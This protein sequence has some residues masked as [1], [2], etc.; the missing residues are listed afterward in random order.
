MRV[1]L[2]FALSISS[3]FAQGSFSTLRGLVTDSTGAVI[4]AA[5]IT[6]KEPATGVLVREIPAD[7]QGAFEIP[8]LRAGTY[9]LTCSAPGF[10]LFTANQIALAS[11]QL[12]RL[13][14]QLSVADSTQT[15]NVT[16][17][18]ALINTETG[19]I[20]GSYDAKK[21]ADVPLVDAYPSPSAMLTVIPGFQGGSGGLGGVR[22][23]GQGLG[24]I[25][26]AI[27][28]INNDTAGQVVNS[29]QYEEVNA[30]VVNAPAESS[31]IASV[32][33]ITKRGAN[34]FHGI[35]YYKFFSSAFNARSFFAPRRTP[36][37]QH[38]WDLELGGAIIKNKTFF[39]AS[40]FS[41]R[42]PLGSFSTA[43]VPTAAFRNGTFANAI[44]DPQTNQP[45]PGNQIPASRVSPVS[46]KIQD[47]YLPLPTS[48]AAA[49]N[50]AFEVPFPADLFRGDWLFWRLDHNFSSKN[51]ADVRWTQRKT[52]YVLSSGL[53]GQFWTRKRDHQ[54]WVASD[55]H[56]FSPS[57]INTL[58]FGLS[59]DFI[60]DGDTVSGRTPLD[61]S[62]VLTEI[63]LLGSNPSGFKGQ[64]FPTI[65][66]T[67]LTG[68][69][70]QPGGVVNDNSAY[71]INQSI[72]KTAG[73]HVWKSGATV[74]WQ[75][76]FA[77]EIPNYGSVSFDGTLSGAPYADFLLG[78]PR[79]SSRT[80]PIANRRQNATEIG[81]FS[82]DSFKV[83]NRL[84][85]EYGLRWDYYTSPVYAD[86]LMYNFDRA[87]GGIIVPQAALAKVSPLYPKNIAISAG[88]PQPT[89]S[90]SNLRPRFSAAYRITPKF[91]IRGG[92]G[93]FTER[94]ALFQ[95]VSG[96]GPFQIAETYQNQ[97]GQTQGL[98]SF[99]NPYP[100]S[101]ATATVASQ[102]VVSFPKQTTNGILHQYNLSLER[103]IFG[104]GLRGSYVGSLGR[105][106]NYS[107]NA[108][109][110][111]PSLIAF[112]VN[113]RPF[114]NLV[115]V[116]DFRADG[117]SYYQSAQ[118]EAKRR[119]GDFQ[120]DFN[121]SYQ[122]NKS[123]YFNLENPYS[124]L[125]KWANEANTR[126][127]YAVGSVVWAAPVGRG[128]R[129]LSNAPKAVDMAIG[130]WQFYWLS[131]VASGLFF[132]PSYS[133]A[134][135]SNTGVNGG[136][137]DLI[138]NP[139]G[140]NQTKNQWFDPKAY[141]VPAAGRFGNALPNSLVSQPL[142]VHHLSLIKKFPIKERLSFTF[143]AAISN[144][145]NHATFN[146]PLNNISVAGT[147]AFS[148][149]VGVFSSN[150]RGAFR[151][152]T[153]KGRFDF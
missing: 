10:S 65:S 16:A 85:L 93:M 28:G 104:F 98:I 143:T 1:L 17:G 86:G 25:I 13:D 8:G 103:E 83:T 29:E 102:S 26:V 146:N 137:P 60:I 49:N 150:E 100:A 61:G 64:G 53:P 95:R 14:V 131:Y 42:I 23:N 127:H 120:V 67:G 71:T 91:V 47:K 117:S 112:N 133:G 132:S 74:Q 40:W 2:L 138:G 134:S 123:N 147:G 70:L 4:P 27:D 45:F 77:G 110:P 99:P 48:L 128:K 62:Q 35:A 11:G 78:F 113:R 20:S 87:T 58:Q 124:V 46:A 122:V 33:L 140:I 56:I 121:Y 52:P 41:Q 101:L 92:Y 97:A 3:T 9:S 90:K 7:A 94:I 19:A 144:L 148:S 106:L 69:S 107:L 66:V 50:L 135:P 79:S 75:R 89:P 88:N 111:E 36:Y 38:E 76:L 141:A 59:T 119:L 30:T 22:A 57:L 55:T 109:Q 39:Y 6:L 142:N 130:Q 21:H 151:Q 34:A 145:F 149:T 18:V 5:K 80:N 96:G 152:M 43:T 32:Q 68:L 105:G 129:L 54:Q 114:P 37:L 125:D 118:V 115:G 108:N 81:F 116:T 51:S 12:R 63:G 73:K 44:R 15:V 82:Q 153:L 72:T 136:L 24:Q 139:T 31:R 126:R 84:T